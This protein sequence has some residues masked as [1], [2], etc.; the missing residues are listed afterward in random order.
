MTGSWRWRLWHRSKY[1]R[2]NACLYLK[3]K[4]NRLSYVCVLDWAPGKQALRWRFACRKLV[5]EQALSEPGLDG[6]ERGRTNRRR[7][8]ALASASGVGML[9]LTTLQ[10]CGRVRQFVLSFCTDQ[11]SGVGCP[12]AE[13]DITLSKATSFGWKW[14]PRGSHLSTLNRWHFQLGD[15]MVPSIHNW[16][17][18]FFACFPFSTDFF[19]LADWLSVQMASDKSV[20]TAYAWSSEGLTVFDLYIR[21]L[22]HLWY[23]WVGQKVR[24]GFL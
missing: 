18:P 6:S 17:C 4:I 9:V 24:S 8:E 13:R 21:Q 23:I 14:S 7:I 20:F 16:V 5:G 22:S 15:V 2:M 19:K 1:Q 11:T 3:F 12:P 10:R